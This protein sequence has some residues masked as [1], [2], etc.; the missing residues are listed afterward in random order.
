MK[1]IIITLISVISS[2]PSIAQ[3]LSLKS[4]IMALEGSNGTYYNSNGIEIIDYSMDVTFSQSNIDS[5]YKGNIKE[6]Y[7]LTVDS[8]ISLKNIL[9]TDTTRLYDDVFATRNYH[10]VQKE[11][12]NLRVICMTYYGK[13]NL[14]LYYQLFDIIYNKTVPSNN[15]HNDNTDSIRFLNKTI[16]TSGLC[17]W[18]DANNIQCSYFGQINWSLHTSL[19][20]A[21]QAKEIQIGLNNIKFD[22]KIL[23]NE[24]VIIKVFG[25]VTKAQRIIYDPSKLLPSYYDNPLT[26]YYIADEINGYFVNFTVS[27]FKKDMLNKSGLPSFLEQIINLQ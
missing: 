22:I 27:H 16:P 17:N 6:G 15:Y 14:N 21:Q 25:K 12:K 3:K 10:F 8:N 13:V 18:Q 5:I 1:I 4:T 23:S 2:L 7:S 9:L 11:D 20:S 19:A 26:T 24:E